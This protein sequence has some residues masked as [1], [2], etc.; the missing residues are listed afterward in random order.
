MH[1]PSPPSE[2]FTFQY[3]EIKS[4]AHGG[5]AGRCLIFTFQYGEIKRDAETIEEPIV[6]EFTF[7]YGEIKSVRVVII[8][9]HLV[10]IYIPVWRD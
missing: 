7:Q 2:R 10:K 3:G 4:V 5:G 1:I 8:R 9:L 6:E